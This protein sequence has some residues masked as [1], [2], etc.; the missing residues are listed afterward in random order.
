VFPSLLFLGGRH[1]S[2]SA[3]GRG[4]WAH[5]GCGAPGVS[6]KFSEESDVWW[7]ARESNPALRWISRL[8]DQAKH[9]H[10]H[11][12]ATR[13]KYEAIVCMPLRGPLRITFTL[14]LK[15]HR[16]LGS[17]CSLLGSCLLAMS[18]L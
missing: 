9:P 4:S 7:T 17:G 3:G 2:F 14:F 11:P 18:L 8:V 15:T 10:T 5:P 1:L 13:S 6:G 16:C 12:G